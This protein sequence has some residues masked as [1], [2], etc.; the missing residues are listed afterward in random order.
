MSF[1]NKKIFNIS[2]NAFGLDLSE[3][4]V[5]VV[6]LEKEGEG[7]KLVSYASSDIPTGSISNGEII[8]KE[9]I[10][11]AIEKAMD[12]SGPKKIRTK[13]VICSLPETKAFLRIINVPRMKE[14]E[15]REAIKW[16]ME[17]NIPLPIDQVYYDWQILEKS[18]SKKK[19]EMSV[20]VV[21]V[22]R[23]VVNCF[24]E[25]LEAVGLNVV[26]ME[27]ESIAQTRSLIGEKDKD[28]T[29]LVIDLGD[30]RTSFFILV[31]NI[32]CFTSSIPLSGGS[33]TDAIAK[34]FNITFPEAEKAKINYGIGSPMKNDP[35][36]KAVK[37]I[38][39]NF[40]SEI[41]KSIDFYLLGL[42]YSPSIDKIVMC[43]G[44]ANT[45]G[46]IPYLSKRLNKKIELGNPW[47]NFNMGKNLPMI[48]REKSVQYSTAIG[49][50]L[51]GTQYYEDLS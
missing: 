23:K 2:K 15:A 20:L 34:S 17:A 31:G 11:R 32:P 28:K 16:E 30:R 35:I 24:V 3:L 19:E 41:D 14:D 37:P 10:V 48:E 18:F 26:G 39:E 44:G 1:L 36:F 47:V 38:L 49:L 27:I 8:K 5:K 50:A 33:L 40:V 12:K 45:K 9:N 22:S 25:A 43:G 4:S 6:Q 46:I 29:T 42:Q 21:A 7:D 13:E 51:K